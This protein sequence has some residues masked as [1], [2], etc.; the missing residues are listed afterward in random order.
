MGTGLRQ[1]E[2]R[3]GE[4]EGAAKVKAFMG[5]LS[6]RRWMIAPQMAS[7]VESSALVSARMPARCYA[8]PTWVGW[9]C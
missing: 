8:A 4:G 6:S 9:P 7:N 1:C 5:L 2:A 3:Q